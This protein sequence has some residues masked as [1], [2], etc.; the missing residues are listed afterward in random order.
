MVPCLAVHTLYQR[1][2]S[3][4]PLSICLVLCVLVWI[5]RQD[6]LAQGATPIIHDPQGFFGSPW[7]QSL[8]DRPDL[9]K[10]DSTETLGIFTVLSGPPQVE[11]IAF[12]SVKLYSLEGKYARALFRYRGES[13]HKQILDWLESQYGK[14]QQSYGSMMRGLNQQYTWRGPETE[15]AITYHGFRQRGLLIAESRIFAPLFLD[16]LSDSGH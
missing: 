11:G 5:G 4:P 3:Y 13:V 9:K 1:F 6:G 16:A 8:E 12:E 10:V 2:S 7:G 14:I 15:I